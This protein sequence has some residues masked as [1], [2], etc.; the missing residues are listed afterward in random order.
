MDFMMH[1]FSWIDCS[2]ASLVRGTDPA[3]SLGEKAKGI[4]KTAALAIHEV[5]LTVR[6]DGSDTLSSCYVLGLL[7]EFSRAVKCKHPWI[8]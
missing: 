8:Y 4:L 1:A 6:G 7:P 2:E 5:V 3:M